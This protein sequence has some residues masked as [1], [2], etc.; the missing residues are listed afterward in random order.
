M[1]QT[2][3][4]REQKGFVLFDRKTHSA[5]KLLPVQRIL[6]VLALRVR[7]RGVEGLARLQRL[8]DGER[9]GSIQDVIAEKTIQASMELVGPGFRYDVDDRAARAAQLRGIVAA[10][11][12]ELI[13]GILAQIQT[14]A[15]AIIVGFT[16]VYS[17][18]VS[19][20]VAPV[21]RKAAL[22]R[23]FNAEL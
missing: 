7:C 4:R 21:E 18:T 6:H 2:L 16:S 10:V 1:P 17:H 15:A 20:A 12:L 8:A 22:R 3:E 13:H 23:L 9:V 14:C 19:S 11:D 5:A